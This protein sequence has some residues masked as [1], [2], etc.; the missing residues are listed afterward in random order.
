MLKSSL[1]ALTYLAPCLALALA[2]GG[3]GESGPD[4]PVNVIDLTDGAFDRGCVAPTFPAEQPDLFILDVP[5]FLLTTDAARQTTSGQ[6]IVLPGAVVEVEIPVNAATRQ[7][8]MELEDVSSPGSIIHREEVTTGGNE[9]IELAFVPTIRSRGRYYMKL[10]L[11]GFDCRER[12]VV[13]DLIDC[14]L[15]ID[16]T[17]PPPE[18]GI[19]APYERTLFEDGD[20]VRADPTCIDLGGEP[21]VGSGTIV[22]Q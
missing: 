10:T 2:C 21:G 15:E 22:I 3:D 11:C 4:L 20:F 12:Q 14:P 16:P 1:H 8:T 7:V 13:F 5:K 17:E 19:N 6:A 18:C 9:V